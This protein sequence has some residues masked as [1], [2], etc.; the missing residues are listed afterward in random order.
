LLVC[1]FI[2]LV[3]IVVLK[4]IDPSKSLKLSQSLKRSS[5]HFKRSSISETRP[6]I[7]LSDLFINETDQQIILSDNSFI[8]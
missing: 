4:T 8:E 1:Y 6:Q 2:K 7:I 3:Q 5:N